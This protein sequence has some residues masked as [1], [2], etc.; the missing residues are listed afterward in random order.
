MKVPAKEFYKGKILVRLQKPY[1]KTI[2]A[3]VNIYRKSLGTE[4][5][6]FV[7][8]FALKF[9]ILYKSFAIII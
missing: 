9:L 6:D 8:K 5:K 7:Y 1:S 3:K 4:H 2:I